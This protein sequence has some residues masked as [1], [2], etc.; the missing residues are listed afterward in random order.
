[1]TL[2][3]AGGADVKE[4]AIIANYAAGVVCGKVGV[5]PIEL[6]ELVESVQYHR[7]EGQSTHG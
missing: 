1:M 6:K 5:Q 3:L 2:A 4:A 7:K